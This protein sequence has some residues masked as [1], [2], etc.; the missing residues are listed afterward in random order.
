MPYKAYKTSNIPF[1][2]NVPIHWEVYPFCAIAQ[3]KS[4][5]NN[6]N[7]ELLSVFLNA[8][9]IK[10]NQTNGAQVHKPSEDLSKYQLVEPGDLV[11]NNQQAWRGSVGVSKYRGI[12]SP[13][14]YVFKLSDV[15][16]PTFANYLFRDLSM[17]NQFVLSSKGVGSI[18]RNL[19][20]PFL[21]RT[22]VLLPSIEEQNK[23]V[24][25]LDFQLA[26]INKFIKVKKK[27]ILVLKEQMQAVINDAVTKG[28]NPNVKMKP[29][30]IDW[31]GDIPE[32]W[33]LIKLKFL[34]NKP[35]QYGANEAGIE[36]SEY[37]PRYIRITD[38]SI[39][40][41]LKDENKL[42]LSVDAA[43]NYML[44][45]GDILFARSGATV[46]KTFLFKSEYGESC[47]AG[48]LIRFSPNQ[49]MVLPKFVYNFTQSTAYSL[50]LNKIFIQATIQNVSA[51]KYKNL[52]IPLPTLEEQKRILDFININ[53]MK[54][55]VAIE[56]LMKEVDL[57]AEYRNRLI[58]DVVTGKVD[59]S[60]MVI[61]EIVM[62]DLDID[63]FDEETVNRDE[64]LD[65]EECE[66]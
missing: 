60:E 45:D 13:A 33:N 15:I 66:V 64:V 36:Y 26:K 58:S 12:V 10:Y 19:Y 43:K 34:S 59:V 49:E 8:G 46:G 2:S 39:D 44:N 65:P 35:F 62:E 29:S 23:I 21:K 42:S 24:K 20:F 9:V 51:E 52:Q 11:L 1:V 27:L 6:K 61:D 47:Y 53:T 54:F 32:G 28:I 4:I 25:Y 17:V 22:R 48:Y 37:L 5:T 55:N 56:K 16:N 30:G 41:K 63:G 40:G 57:I 50:W 31:L 3:E 7:E 38:V 18:Q 14:Y